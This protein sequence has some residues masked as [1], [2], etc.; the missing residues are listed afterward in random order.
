M[1]GFLIEYNRRTR[2]SHITE[3]ATSQEA[4]QHQ[5]KL[6]EE[7]TDRDIEIVV[8]SANSL[9]TIKH[10]H[11]RYFRDAALH[12]RLWGVDPPTELFNAIQAQAAH[13]GRSTL[14]EVSAILADA[15]ESDGGA[16][17]GSL[18]ADI[19]SRT[20]LTASKAQNFDRHDQPHAQPER[21]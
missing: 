21:R 18:F 2:V 4:V 1:A 16:S 15:A 6:E 8:L 13:N 9:D 7:R 11:T 10:T 20:E 5:L 14:A 12:E 17:L 19:G 3:F